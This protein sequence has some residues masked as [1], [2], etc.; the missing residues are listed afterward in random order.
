MAGNIFTLRMIL[1]DDE[2][3]KRELTAATPNDF[4]E[5]ASHLIVVCSD[6]KQVVRAYGKKGERYASQQAGAA[7]ENML[8]RAED[9][10]LASCWGGALNGV[11]VKRI[12]AIPA[13]FRVEAI[14]P[15]GLEHLREQKKISPTMKY[16][17][18]YNKFGKK[19]W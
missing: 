17:L 11:A 12:L 4:L 2:A 8:L 1:V 6:L 9:L 15:V 16:I 5:D 7:I 10:G 19:N 13:H 18:S 14:L 3:K